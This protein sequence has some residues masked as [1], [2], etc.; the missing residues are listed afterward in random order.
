MDAPAQKASL[1]SGAHG[2][3]FNFSAGPATLPV[4]VLEQTQSDLIN[5]Q[6]SGMSVMEMSHRGPE[7][8]RIIEEAE[9]DLRK[10]MEIPDNYKVLFLQ[11]GASQQ[12]SAIPFN[13]TQPEDTVDQAVTGSWSK[14]AAEE[15]GKYCKVNIA[16]KGDNKSVPDRSTWKLTPGARYLHYCDNETIQGVEF[17]GAPEVG[18]TLLVADMSSNFCSKPVDVS[19]YALIYAG[20]QKNIGPAGV[21]VVIVREDLV[22]KAR[23]DTPVTLDYK[24]M[25]GSLY[26][27]P[28]C[29]SIYVCGLVFK[30]LLAAGGLSGVKANNDAKAKLVYDAIEAS[31]GFYSSPVEPSV[32]SNMNIPFT[33]PSD[34]ALEKEFLQEASKK[35]MVQLKG[36]RSVGGMR[37]SVYNSMPLEGAQALADFMKDFQSRH[38]R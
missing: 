19:K 28:P 13:L 16:A 8:T 20:A 22:G 24:I 38:C 32:R 9:A 10:L 5:Y 25:E 34:A 26:N 1:A 29:W 30:H 31:D 14:K 35:N 36:H 15:A 23:A 6:G 3:V 18:D 21:V 7:F 12:F 2:R 11:G 17:S 27:T 4:P 37:A 33:I